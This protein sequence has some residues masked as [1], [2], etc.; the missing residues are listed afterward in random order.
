MVEV[1]EM[2]ASA[3]DGMSFSYSAGLPA[4]TH[5]SIDGNVLFWIPGEGN[6]TF[7]E[8]HEDKAYEKESWRVKSMLR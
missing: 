3:G 6:L 8:S 5:W 4:L 1:G 7:G 2:L